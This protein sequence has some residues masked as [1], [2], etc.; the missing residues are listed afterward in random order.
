M[1]DTNKRDFLINEVPKLLKNLKPIREA[2][3][4]LMTPQHMI[5]HLTWVIKSSAKKYE[6][7][8]E[9]PANER[10][11]GFQKFIQKGS[12]LKY[13]PST[14]TKADL[15]PL[16]YNSLDEA[17]SQIPEAIQ[18]FYDFWDTNLDY[19]PYSSFMGEMPFE[20]LELFHYMHFR[21]HLWQFGLIENYP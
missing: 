13:R 16:K 17:I 1:K 5:E 3:F 11:L 12:I 19:L 4:G 15:P 14:K 10:Q 18:R 7:I 2:N 8:R 9:N 21:Y 20:D 6:G